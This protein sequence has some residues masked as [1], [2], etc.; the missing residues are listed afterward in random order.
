MTVAFGDTRGHEAGD[1]LDAY[2]QGLRVVLIIDE[3]HKHGVK[4]T[5]HLCSVG[6]REAV[7]TTATPWLAVGQAVRGHEFHYADGQWHRR[8]GVKPAA[9]RIEQRVDRSEDERIEQLLG[10]HHDLRRK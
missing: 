2:A 10:Q 3:A 8:D 6:Y 4:V 9:N 7:A 5:A 1:V